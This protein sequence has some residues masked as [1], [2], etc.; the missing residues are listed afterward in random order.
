MS[1]IKILNADNQTNNKVYELI[2]NFYLILDGNDWL[3]DYIFWELKLLSILGFKLDLKKMV[4]KR[5]I[6]N[7]ILY[8]VETLNEKK[9]VPNFFIEE[10][11]DPENQKDLLDG[12]K[13]VSDFMDKTIL[14]PNN[15]NIPISRNQFI[16]SLK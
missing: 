11:Y 7:K 8:V 3:K 9:I 2:I 12:L 5:T 6:N 10:N 14:K 13:L 15:L 16:N 1:L 4:T